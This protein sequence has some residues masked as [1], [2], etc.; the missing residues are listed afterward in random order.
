[1][2]VRI[3]TLGLDIAGPRPVDSC[4]HTDCAN[5]LVPQAAFLGLVG[6]LQVVLEPT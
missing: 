4:G 3:E 5:R 1:M 2:A 6:W